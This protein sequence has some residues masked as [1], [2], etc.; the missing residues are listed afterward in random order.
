MKLQRIDPL[1][2]ERRCRELFAQHGLDAWQLR[3]SKATKQCG[4]CSYASKTITLS[5]WQPDGCFEDT[6]LH[7]IAHALTPGAKHG[8]QW[9]LKC[10]ELGCKPQACESM[11]SATD[12][13][14][15][16]RRY[17]VYCSKCNRTS[18]ASTHP[19]RNYVKRISH[20]CHAPLDQEKLSCG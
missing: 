6:L 5:I 20:C 16:L 10:L 18:S 14:E 13:P 12:L 7:E 2:A 15:E 1:A 8:Y 9:K 4:L 11:S 17:R 19:R 3:F